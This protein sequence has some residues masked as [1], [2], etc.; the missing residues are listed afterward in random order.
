MS[1]IYP[2]ADISFWRV[3]ATSQGWTGCALIPS[4]KSNSI[5]HCTTASN[6]KTNGKGNSSGRNE[7]PSSWKSKISSTF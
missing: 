5:H 2:R 3:T 4:L 7:N 6:L 1:N